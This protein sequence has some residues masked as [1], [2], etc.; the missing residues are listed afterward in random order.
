MENDGKVEEVDL[1]SCYPDDIF[2]ETI[3]YEE[4]F[5][6]GICL[7]ILR[8]PLMEIRNQ[9]TFGSHCLSLW[10]EQKE[11]IELKCPLCNI[12]INGFEI[13]SNHFARKIMDSFKVRC[14]FHKFDCSWTGKLE[15]L[16]THLPLCQPYQLHKKA[17]ISQIV[18]KIIK[19]LDL[20]INP[21]LKQEHKEIFENQVKNWE[22]LRNDNRDWKWWWWADNPWWFAPC[23]ECND[24]W[25]KYEHLVDPLEITRK[26]GLNIY[27]KIEQKMFSSKTYEN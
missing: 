5:R 17:N 6:C 20:E 14:Y 18:E 25:H 16:N 9:H 3:A 21:H 2:I 23:V 8:N 4:H 15:E 19:I 1:I 7:G 11:L 26:R 13:I 24:L 10:A 12:E 22:W 27:N